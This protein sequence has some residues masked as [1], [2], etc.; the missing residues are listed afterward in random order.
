MSISVAVFFLGG[1]IFLIVG[2]EFL[3]RGASR[4]ARKIGI[5]RVIIGLTIVA[6]GTSTPELAVSIQAGLKGQADIALGN[7]VGSNIFNVLLI[8][9]VSA[10]ITP[11][12]V[13]RQLVKLDVPIM[14][15]V[16]TLPLVLGFNGAIDRWE[17]GIMLLGML[18]YMGFLLHLSRRQRNATPPGDK[19]KAG[20]APGGNMQWLTN[21]LFITS[22]LIML[23]FGSKWFIDGAVVLAALLGV[24]DL[25]IGLIL[26]AAGTSLPELATSVVASIRGEKDIAVGNIV[27]SNIFNVLVVLGCASATSSDVLQVSEIA[28]RF[29]IPFMI[30]IS[31]ACLPIF[32][33]GN[34]IARWEGMLFLSYYIAY[35]LFL[36]YAASTHMAAS[37]YRIT[38]IWFAL[39]IV[40]LTGIVILSRFISLKK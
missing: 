18:L 24:S 9:G 6:F 3:V 14:V 25:V 7:A 12:V 15:F 19:N 4:F 31:I 26:I 40:V 8:L 1:L 13:S 11:L 27:G 23:V 2:A 30:A 16:A 5:S 20:H 36:I 34:I 37:G 32:F 38:L 35:T 33:T 22:G 17:G 29:D 10:S 39:P 21:F 28:V